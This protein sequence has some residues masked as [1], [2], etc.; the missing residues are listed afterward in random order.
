MFKARLSKIQLKNVP[1]E[2]QGA[3]RLH[4]VTCQE[5]VSIDHGNPNPACRRTIGVTLLGG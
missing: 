2:D 4:L 3:C 5:E 1:M